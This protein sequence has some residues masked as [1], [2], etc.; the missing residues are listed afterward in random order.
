[1]PINPESVQ[2]EVGGLA[3]EKEV[4]NG[5]AAVRDLDHFFLRIRYTF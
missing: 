4:E 2:N 5:L 1:M 3:Y